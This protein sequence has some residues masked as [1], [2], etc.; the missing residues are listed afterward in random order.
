[1]QACS[2]PIH[3]ASGVSDGLKVALL[4]WLLAGEATS[5]LFPRQHFHCVTYRRAVAIADLS[6]IFQRQ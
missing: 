3:R 5:P 1:M 2:P 4:P 6:E